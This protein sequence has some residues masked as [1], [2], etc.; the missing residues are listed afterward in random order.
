MPY[1]LVVKK[2]QARRPDL[3]GVPHSGMGSSPGSISDWLTGRRRS[4][5][6]LVSTFH[7]WRQKVLVASS[8]PSDLRFCSPNGIR[9]RVFTLRGWSDPPPESA[10]LRRSPG[11]GLVVP[12]GVRPNRWVPGVFSSN[13]SSRP[14]T[15]AAAKMRV[16]T[17]RRHGQAHD[18]PR[19][20]Q[21]VFNPVLHSNLAG[22]PGLW[23]LAPPAVPRR[24]AQEPTNG[25]A[26][27]PLSQ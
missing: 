2:L 17:G 9:T 1:N 10:G 8:T 18:L 7:E 11:Q 12:A 5:L 23:H 27:R 6:H 13:A 15:R 24:R 20:R 22:A 14:D 4:C 3:G 16:G 19:P 25:R 21:P 26:A